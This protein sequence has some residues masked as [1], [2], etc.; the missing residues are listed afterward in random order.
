MNCGLENSCAVSKPVIQIVIPKMK[1]I[2]QRTTIAL[3]LLVCSPGSGLTRDLDEIVYTSWGQLCSVSPGAKRNPNCL[4][5][6]IEFGSPRWNPSGDRIVAEAGQHDG[7]QR[8][9]ILNRQGDQ[10]A[11]LKG[12]EGF[13]RPMWSPDGQYIYAL[14]YALKHGLGRWQSS[15]G[16][17]T[18]VPVVGFESNFDFLQM[19]SFS[20]SGRL[21]ALLVDKFDTILVAEVGGDS[22]LLKRSFPES[23]SYVSQSVWLDDER[24]LFV[25]K[26][27]STRGELW[28]LNLK[29][30]S[31]KK[32]GI[33]GL[34][35]RDSIELSPNRDS[36]VVCA[37]APDQ[38]S[39]WSLWQYSLDS[40]D[41]IRISG[42]SEDVNPSWRH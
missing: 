30:V 13:I 36:V 26:K 2:I 35:L 32:V 28:H 33:P 18:S 34:W 17:F 37:V 31:P 10:I 16:N 15:G 9:V 21:A 19:I 22:W 38:D 11:V 23:F 1:P 7:P 8:L 29:D 24:L 12:S 41:A 39:K 14:S 4:R 5:A 40:G 25:G 6:D 27:G 20:P 3:V 42:G